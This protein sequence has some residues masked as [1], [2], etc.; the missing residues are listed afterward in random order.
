MVG[1]NREQVNENT[2]CNP[3]ESQSDRLNRI[4]DIA[5]RTTILA[6]LCD[7][8]Q[9]LKDI[10]ADAST[11]FSDFPAAEVKQMPMPDRLEAERLHL[12]Q[13]EALSAFTRHVET[14]LVCDQPRS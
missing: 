5:V 2:N 11:R 8:G 12:E 1:R 7:E 3:V 6:V 13:Q 4:T 9:K 10:L 14:C